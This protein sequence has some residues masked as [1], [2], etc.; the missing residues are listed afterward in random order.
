MVAL[1]NRL[2]ARDENH[3]FRIEHH[4]SLLERRRHYYRGICRALYRL[5]HSLTFVEQDIYDRQKHR[6]LAKD[7]EYA[8]VVICR[9]L[10]EITE[11]W[12]VRKS[13]LIVKCSGVGRYDDYSH[14]L[15]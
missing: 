8:E 11:S 2:K 5:G 3:I 12:I 14:R 15:Y 13:D 9:D 1:I 6:D 4:L 10:D 7:P